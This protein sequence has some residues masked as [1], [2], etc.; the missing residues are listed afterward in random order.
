MEK[1][2]KRL[3]ILLGT[4]SVF[5]MGLCCYF[6]YTVYKISSV[7]GNDCTCKDVTTT[8]CVDATYG[9]LN[10]EELNKFGTGDISIIKKE[11][12]L[13]YTFTLEINGRININ[14]L[15]HISNVSDAK[16]IVL[17]SPP[18]SDSAL[19]VLTNSGDVYKYNT[20]NY[21][22]GNLT[23]TKINDYS[24]IERIINFERRIGNS[25]GCNYIIL[26]DKNGKYS[27]LDSYCV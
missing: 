2:N 10:V 9:N 25:G 4:L 13:N 17:F 1:E 8:N 15:D 6:V 12:N 14:F 3:K 27:E 7:S 26:I 21:D 23:A 5:A 19:Y 24:G 20:S 16:D 18:S 11:G 22:S